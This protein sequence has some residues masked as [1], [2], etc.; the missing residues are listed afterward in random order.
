MHNLHIVIIGFKNVGK[1]SIGIA[2]AERLKRRFI[3]LD[4]KICEHHQRQTGNKMTCREIMNRHGEKYFRTI[5][6]E[7]LGE[8]IAIP[9]PLVLAVGG[10]TPMMEENFAL[11]S[12]HLVVLIAAPKG[13]VFERIM[14]NG[15]PAFFPKDREAFETF[16]QLWG[17]REPVFKKLARMTVENTGSVEEAVA[18]IEKDLHLHSK[19]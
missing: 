7:V 4:E 8:I 9:E 18:K 10:G 17:E 5:E 16:Q 19:T 14:I 1:S 15:K 12:Q 3:D 11:L 2:L 6:H 13:I